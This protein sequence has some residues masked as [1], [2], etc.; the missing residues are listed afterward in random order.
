VTNADGEHRA[1]RVPDPEHARRSSHLWALARDVES[2]EELNGP[3][4]QP[5]G[6]GEEE[7]EPL[8]FTGEELDTSCRYGDERPH[9]VSGRR[10]QRDLSSA[11]GLLTLDAAPSN[12]YRAPSRPVQLRLSPRERT[13]VAKELGCQ[14]WEVGPCQG[15]ATPIHRYG[16]RSYIACRTCRSGGQG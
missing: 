13:T 10:P 3:A 2:W 12:P 6:S 7:D 4:V 5:D 14:P 15:C 8:T 9:P 1:L 11:T 16:P